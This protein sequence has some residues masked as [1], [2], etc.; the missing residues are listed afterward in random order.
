MSQ[1]ATRTQLQPDS[2]SNAAES[3]PSHWATAAILTGIVM[4][5][6]LG[7]LYWIQHNVVL[8]GHDATGYLETSLNYFRFLTELTPQTLY[9][10]FTFPP[11][12][13]P[14]LYLAVQP[15]LHG[16]GAD[17]DGAQLLNAVLLAGV[18]L[19][20]YCLT[21]VVAGR[22]AALTAAFLVGL[23]PMLSAMARLYY[24]EMFLTA[25]VVFNLL[26]LYRS[27]GF[28]SRTWSLLWGVSLGVGLLVKWTMPIYIA[29]PTLWVFW[30]GGLIQKHWTGLRAFRI[31]WRSSGLA[32]AA[33]LA[34]T[35]LW[36]LPNRSEL[37]VTPLGGWTYW[38]WVLILTGLAY[39]LLR[40]SAPVTNWWAGLLLGVSLASL[41]YLPHA[42]FGVQL[43]AVDEERSQEAIGVLASGNYLRYLR[44]IYAAHL[45]P[46]LFLDLLTDGTG[47]MGLGVVQTAQLVSPCSLALADPIVKLCVAVTP[48]PVQR[49]ESCPATAGH[50]RSGGRRPLALSTIGALGDR[51]DLA[52]CTRG[53]VEHLYLRRRDAHPAGDQATL[54]RIIVLRS[55]GKWRDR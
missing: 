46:L 26:A 13:T 9:Q 28:S 33:G 4:F 31:G 34:L 54:G 6:L 1:S 51:R 36:Y 49:T 10:A 21:R 11:Y 12:R 14:G 41:W 35:A 7:T 37:L 30:S 47:A 15:F 16:F 43:L 50:D 48:V 40:P 2:A 44:Y 23:L 22:A 8:I 38:G 18:I 27:R 45:G 20:T 42:D 5:H 17:M 29:L 39:A 55:T 25:M 32:L 24:T 52:G 3:W 19:L 53:T